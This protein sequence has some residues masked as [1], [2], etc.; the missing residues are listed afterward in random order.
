MHTPLEHTQKVAEAIN[1]AET[2]RLATEALVRWMGENVGN[3]LVGLLNRQ[4][5]GLQIFTTPGYTPPPEVMEWLQ[6]ADSWLTWE[7][8]EGLYWLDDDHPIEGLDFKVPSLLVPL[9]YEQYLRGILWVDGRKPIH[10]SGG[11]EAVLL[12]QVLAA[13]LHLLEMNSGWSTL[14]TS[15]NEF[16]RALSQISSNEDIWEVVYAQIA[17]LFDTS[18]FYVGLLNPYDNQLTLPLASEDGMLVYYGSIPLSGLS[19]AVIT[20]GVALHFRDLE[21]EADRLTALNVEFGDLEPGMNARSWLGVPLR[22]RKNEVIGVISIQNELSNHYSDPDLSLLMVIGVH[23]SQTIENRQLL[24]AEQERR[25]IASTLIDVSQVV[26]STLDYEDVLERILEQLHRVLE[27]DR[28]SIMLPA[29]DC[30]DGSRMIVS[31]SQGTQRTPR[32]QEIRLQENS[33]SMR[34]WVSQQP[35]VLDDIRNHADRWSAGLVTPAAHQTRAWIGVPMVIQNRAIGLIAVEKFTVGYYNER[36]ASTAFALG[37]QAAIAVENARLHAEAALALEILEQRARRLDSIH[38][39]ATLLSSTLDRDTILNTAARMLAELFECDH[40][41]VVL[42]NEKDGHAYVVADY[43]ARG[44]VGQR[45]PVENNRSFEKLLRGSMAMAVYDSDPEDD[46]THQSLR[47]LGFR[48]TLLAPLIVHDGVIGSIGLDSIAPGR[49][50]TPEEHETCM[51]IAGQVALALKNAQLYEQAL[52]ANRLKTEFLANMSHELRT[53]LNAIIGYSEMLLSQVYGELNPKQNDRLMRVNIGGKHL[54]ELINDVLDLSKI[55]AGQMDLSLAP[56]SISDV[57][58][59]AIADITPQADAK[60]L[61]LYMRMTPELPLVQADAQ[62]IRQIITNLLDN[63]VKFTDEGSV[64][65]ELNIMLLRDGQ[66]ANGAAAPPPQLRVVDGKWLAIVVADTGIGIRPDDQKLI[67]EAFTQ[68]DGSSVRKYEGT[69]LGLAITQRLVK[70]HQGYIWVESTVDKGS[71]FTVLLPLEAETEKL[72]IQEP[73]PDPERPLV[74]II[75]DDPSALQLVQDYLSLYAYQVVSTT[76]PKQALELAKRLHPA[77]VISDV[78]MPEVSGWEVLRQLK[79]DKETSDI[80]VIIVSIIE[81]RTIGYYLGAADYLTKPINRE[82]LLNA[83]DRVAH[84]EPQFPI[85]IVDDDMR[86]RSLLSEIL[87][88]AGFQTAEAESGEAAITWLEDNPASL[89]L[90]D[91]LLPGISGLEVLEKLRENP[92]TEDIPVIAV[93]GGTI[94]DGVT[95]MEGIAQIMQKGTISGNSLVQQV[96]IA[97]NRHRHKKR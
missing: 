57:V 68:A 55:E 88:R 27:Y 39:V 37:R 22:N 24:L 46:G 10:Q 67:F 23:L 84:I 3:T 76:S 17:V 21:A 29:P 86:D 33:L 44:I 16:A 75:D 35:V 1:Q 73:A 6:S 54:L 11:N 26:G 58:Y 66:P 19:R 7:R 64:T 25:K 28:A 9:R 51:T 42:I 59:D 62:R 47:E 49:V 83:I 80:P 30:E 81:Q 50:F 14:L 95:E 60:G 82:S 36:D 31:A 92:E 72:S 77:V 91:L 53:P 96:Q 74:L 65:L 32:G 43:P 79:T 8:W 4:S 15:L 45:I 63:A 41:G 97:L 34:V 70:M 2:P 69:G 93:T 85:L 90:L 61:R 48:S 52:A 38:H 56:L 89:L 78:M 20:H 13:R 12:G 71:S 87:E 94:P 18:S 5:A 40:C